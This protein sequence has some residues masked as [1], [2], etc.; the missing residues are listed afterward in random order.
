LFHHF[1]SF[2]FSILTIKDIRIARN[3][4]VA[5]IN[6]SFVNDESRS[7]LLSVQLE[8]F[9]VVTK[10]WAYYTV[11]IPRDRNDKA[12]QKQILRTVVDVEKALSRSHE[13]FII[14]MVTDA[15]LKSCER[16]F[17]FP[18]EKVNCIQTSKP[19]L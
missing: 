11:R 5:K 2:K 19:S 18:M 16:E 10:M 15:F 8:H 3:K 14:S 9:A 1:F 7:F 4:N 13:N 17:K 6:I 12:Y